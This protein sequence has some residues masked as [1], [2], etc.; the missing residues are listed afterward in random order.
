MWWWSFRRFPGLSFFLPFCLVACA[1][2][3]AA[4]PGSI[5]PPTAHERTVVA[6]SFATERVRA[7][8]Q[9][10]DLQDWT[11]SVAV[12]R[13]SELRPKTLGNVRW[14]LDKKTAQIRVLDPA[15]Y[16]MSFP[17]TLKDIEFTVVHE[18][19][20]LELAPLFADQHR[21][22]ANRRDE[23]YTVNHLADALLK[24]DRSK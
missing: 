3:S 13:A 20:H 24:L 21:T 10:L 12:V 15:D 5:D 11:I 1:A 4:Q 8:Q 18:L 22:E 2:V 14:D 7:W 17:D 23:E 19:I 6:E 16:Q 9:R